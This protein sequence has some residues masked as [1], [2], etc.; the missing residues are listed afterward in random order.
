MVGQVMNDWVLKERVMLK[1][2]V[3]VD[4]GKTDDSRMM[5]GRRSDG[6]P[7][8]YRRGSVAQ[9]LATAQVHRHPPVAHLPANALYHRGVAGNTG[10]WR[11][12]GWKRK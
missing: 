4:E 1:E 6:E 5:L 3:M 8:H 10:G 12:D 11:M 9:E 2:Y 7:Q